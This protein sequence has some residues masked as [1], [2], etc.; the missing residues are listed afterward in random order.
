MKSDAED[1]IEFA[2]QLSYCIK[3][4]YWNLIIYSVWLPCK[5]VNRMEWNKFKEPYSIS[6]FKSDAFNRLLRPIWILSKPHSYLTI[7]YEKAG[8]NERIKSIELCNSRKIIIK[9]SI[10]ILVK[11]W[12]TLCS[13][14]Q[15]TNNTQ[16]I[17]IVAGHC[18]I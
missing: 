7:W 3:R 6:I 9:A 17:R 14:K 5:F 12:N 18:I 1:Y 11:R 4:S 2:S 10:S 8:K 15:N 13:N 16:S